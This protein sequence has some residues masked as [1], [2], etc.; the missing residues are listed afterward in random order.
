MSHIWDR[1]QDIDW[2][3]LS[4][5]VTLTFTQA[6]IEEFFLRVSESLSVYS[7]SVAR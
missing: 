7:P 1:H 5:N 4:R 2:L 6:T 3:A